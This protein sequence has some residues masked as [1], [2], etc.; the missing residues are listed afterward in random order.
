MKE[1]R[2]VFL[3]LAALRLLTAFSCGRAGA[4]DVSGTILD[5]FSWVDSVGEYY[6]VEDSS[7]Q[8]P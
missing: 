6:A 4:K 3:L 8:T 1:V 7:S 5:R 2:Q